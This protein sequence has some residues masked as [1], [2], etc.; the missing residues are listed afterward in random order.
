MSDAATRDETTTEAGATRLGLRLSSHALSPAA[1]RRLTYLLL[2]KSIAEALLVTAV[3]VGFYYYAFN[4]YF[5]GA[6]DVADAARVAGWAVD[7]ARP[8]SRVEVQLYI[9]ERFVAST[10]ADVPRPDVLAAG[11]AAD[12]RH[13]FVFDLPPQRAGEHEARVYF[14]HSSGGG[15][16]RTLQLVG[17]PVSFRVASAPSAPDGSTAG[18]DASHEGAARP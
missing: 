16:R 4:P 11:R 3:A 1:R 18:A 7:A 13:G 10:T 15:A 14:V 12:E 6:V 5:R 17:R 2:A 8:Q 9:D